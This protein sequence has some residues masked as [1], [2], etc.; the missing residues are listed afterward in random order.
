MAA[1][2]EALSPLQG[3]RDPLRCFLGDVR[4]PD[5]LEMAFQD[6]DVVVHAAAIKRIEQA[7]RDPIECIK[8]NIYGTQNV[9]QAAIKTGVQRVVGLS[10][11]KAVSPVNLYGATKLAVEHLLL[12][13]T[14]LAAGKC[15]F[16]V[17]R[18]GN[19]WASRG[20]VIHRWR[21]QHRAGL[22]LR[23]TAVDATRY[24]MTIDDAINL[25]IQVM[26]GS[27]SDRVITPDGLPA[28]AVGDLLDSYCRV[29][30]LEDYPVVVTGLPHYE[31][32]HETMDGITDSSQARRMSTDELRT[33]IC[34]LLNS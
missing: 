20:S 31:K 16:G 8:T 3:I 24:F 25:V 4:D 14:A 5:R 2:E 10:T 29:A 7:Q 11:D 6:I 19:V 26:A 34:Q 17:V 28:Y 30:G 9:I 18:Y 22:P 33:H 23:V 15:S 27:P 32:Q 1:C 13:A 12:A 21:D